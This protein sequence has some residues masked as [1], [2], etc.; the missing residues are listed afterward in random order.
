[1][2]NA[3]Y[4]CG[5]PVGV[6]SSVDPALDLDGVPARPIDF[7]YD[8]EPASLITI[9]DGRGVRSGM[10]ARYGEGRAELEA[11][12]IDDAML[13]V[14][15]LDRRLE[16]SPGTEDWDVE[17]RYSPA[18]VDTG[19]SK[20]VGVSFSRGPVACAGVGILV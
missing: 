12:E 19:V 16:P 11:G 6:G 5:F 14:E 10:L 15:R 1:M 20:M 4:E 7:L 18:S 17:T 8:M 13:D 3:W 2:G 9:G